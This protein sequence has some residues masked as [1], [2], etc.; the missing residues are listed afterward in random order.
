MTEAGQI[1]AVAAAVA[2]TATGAAGCIISTPTVAAA[3]AP[4]NRIKE[5]PMT[6]AD[7]TIRESTQPTLSG[8]LVG[9]SNIWE[10]EL[11]DAH[12]VLAS[13]LSAK[14]SIVDVGSGRAR[15]ESV[16]MGSVI[17]LGADRYS[18]VQVA[19]GEATPGTITLRRLAP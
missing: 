12:G 3:A 10:R 7:I 6:N 14:L 1:T 17:V 15:H 11:S 19:E 4:S 13:R 18:V 2:L 5:P 8:H 16:A 9:V